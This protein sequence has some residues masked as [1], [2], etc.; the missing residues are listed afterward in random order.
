MY[1]SASEETGEITYLGPPTTDGGPIRTLTAKEMRSDLD[2]FE[3]HDFDE[4]E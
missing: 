3:E 2:A 1:F 4:T